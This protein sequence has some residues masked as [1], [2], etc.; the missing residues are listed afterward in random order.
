[1]AMSKRCLGCME[2]YP[3]ELNVCPYC[4]YVEG[5]AAQ[6]ALHMK[7]GTLLH[8]RYIVGRVLG[9]GGF[10]VT[11]IGWDTNMEQKVAIKEYFPSE[12]STRAPGQTCLTVFEGDKAQQFSDGMVKFVDEARRLA[13]CQNIDGIVSVFDS[14]EENQ[15][16]YI[17]M[18]YL[19]GENLDEKLK[20]EGK[21]SIDEA[22]SLLLPVMKSLEEVHQIG[23]IHRDI[24]PDNI[25]ITEEGEAKLIDFGASRYAT[26]SHSKSLTVIVK[27][28]Y[29][30]EEQYRSRGDQGPHTDVH[31]IAATLYKMIT[32]V[33]PPDA[34][35]HR[36]YF[37]NKNRDILAPPSQYVRKLPAAKE[38]AIL[39][40]MNVRIEDRTPTVQQ[41]MEELQAE[42]VDRRAGRIR[43][44]DLF[45]WPLWAKIGIPAVGAVIVALGVLI[46][47]GVIS[48]KS[49]LGQETVV[50]EGMTRVPTLINTTVE[51]AEPRLTEAALLYSI[52]GKEY[53]GEIPADYILSQDIA[54]GAVVLQN[55]VVS[56]IIS[57]GV[58]MNTVP[59]VISLSQEDAVK[60]LEEAGFL[61]ELQECYSQSVA[62]GSVVTQSIAGNTEYEVGGT[63][64]LTI[65]LGIDP[66]AGIEQ[67]PVEV[68]K[69]VGV[70]LEEA[71]KKAEEAGVVLSVKEKCYSTEYKE[72]VVMEQSVQA[73]TEI[74]K[75]ST[76]ELVVS[77]GEE[78]VKVADVVYKEETAAQEALEKQGLKVEVKYTES[79]TVAEGL[80]INQ[81]PKAGERVKPDTLVTLT[82]SKGGESFA[83]PNVEGMTEE[84]ARKL[85]TEEGLS[86]SVAYTYDASFAAGTVISQTIHADT[87]VTKGTKVTLTVNRAEETAAPKITQAVENILGSISLNTT[88]LQLYVGDTSTLTATMMPRGQSVSWSSSNT[89]VATVSGGKITAVGAGS[90]IITAS[91]NYGETTYK[92]TCSVIVN[93]AM[94]NFIS[95]SSMPSKTAYYVGDSLDASGL[96]LK[97]VYNTG[98]TQ[99]ISSGYDCQYDF[100]SAG[101]KTVTVSYAG[102]TAAFS[103]TVSKRSFTVTYVA[104]GGAITSKSTGKTVTQENYQ[105]GEVLFRDLSIVKTGYSF[106]GWYTDSALTAKFSNT[107]MPSKNVTLYAK[108]TANSYQ[109]TFNANGGS[110]ST[111]SKTAV[112][113]NVIGTLPTPV[114][115]YYTF[116]GWYT[117]ASG[118]TKVTSSTVMQ[119]AGAVALYA[120]WTQNAWSGWVSSLPDNVNSANANIQTKTQYRYRDK[121]FGQGTSV[122]AG[123]TKYNET[124]VYGSWGV[125]SGWSAAP[126]TQSDTVNVQTRNVVTK[127][128][129]SRITCNENTGRRVYSV[130]YAVIPNNENCW[131]GQSITLPY[132]LSPTGT[133]T[134]NGV[135]YQMYGSYGSYGDVNVYDDNNTWCADW[136]RDCW[137]NETPAEQHTEYSYQ[138]R[139]KTVTYYYYKWGTWSA[140]Q[141]TSVAASDNRNV[142]TQILYNYQ[143]K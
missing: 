83:M 80:V 141:D 120:H 21:M 61:T 97:V 122:P 7:P 74:L 34:L 32:G 91:M 4:G 68:P 108:W 112:Y 90:A 104:N 92:A 47:T 73:G 43:K 29:S 33:T 140:W 87:A 64:I 116:G 89:N 135:T 44:I 13:K 18:E 114:R 36:A 51:D 72:N 81:S 100:S 54:G 11:Y 46:L 71:M 56:V 76:V 107:T 15:T 96:Q 70:T 111:S 102:K 25:F 35:E 19:K 57:G 82:V 117:S 79:E 84:G 10:G 6:E 121:Q 86:V 60:Q 138:T 132:R 37:E 12:F 58:E 143:M 41:F 109:I 93:A 85:L 16:A 66:S 52:S 134:L 26:T 62:E 8:S 59:N 39:N 14:F 31:A 42:H 40:A 53:S 20:R 55:T 129:Y 128:N 28:G 95:V 30:P 45:R 9:F 23:I 123:W 110:V 119:T 24:A 94:V 17:V 49:L 48:V 130:F 137:Y 99:Y 136:G 88:S 67:V 126:V 127:W 115:D 38:N 75:G 78:I 139:S 3:E 2:T 105:E 142:Y 69:L 65:S 113:G 50:P 22:V 1:M 101:S 98:E 63:I 125:W 118:G 133:E 5:T 77:L 131:W 106:A 27:Q 103:V 124:T